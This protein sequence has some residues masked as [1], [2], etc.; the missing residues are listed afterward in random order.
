MFGM[1]LHTRSYW[2]VPVENNMSV[3][4]ANISTIIAKTAI[5]VQ[6]LAARSKPRS[7]WN[8]E[9]NFAAESANL[10]VKMGGGG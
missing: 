7:L 8:Y 6:Y 10:A 3:K 4:E 9:I 5:T 1:Y 2:A